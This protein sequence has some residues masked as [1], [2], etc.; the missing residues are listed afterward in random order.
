MNPY[1]D[2]LSF[3]F[4]RHSFERAKISE[5]KCDKISEETSP[6]HVH[7][8]DKKNVANLVL[9]GLHQQTEKDTI[10]SLFH[11]QANQFEGIQTY[12]PFK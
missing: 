5:A 8:I 9:L 2:A 11:H 4:H 12:L 10:T 6:R 1:K 3:L 7:Q